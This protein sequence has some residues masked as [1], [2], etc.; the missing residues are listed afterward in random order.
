MVELIT[1]QAYSVSDQCTQA[2]SVH[3]R[4]NTNSHSDQSHTKH[5]LEAVKLIWKR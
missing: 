2:V 5:H 3:F 4:Y 1:Y